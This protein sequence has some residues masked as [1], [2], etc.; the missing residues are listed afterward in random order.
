M[1]STSDPAV[2]K[3]FLLSHPAHLISL[4]FGS[5]LSRFAPG[6]AGTILG[7]PLFLLLS[8]LS[9]SLQISLLALLFIAGCYLCDFTGKALG[10]SDHGS[11]VWDEIV[12]YA[13]VL[14]SVPFHW[15]WWIGAFAAFRFFDIIKP[16]PIS[17]L[18]RRLKNGF[19]VM[20]DD[21]LAAIYAIITLH[22]FK[23]ML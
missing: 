18:D 19:G 20:L 11:I 6:T 7:L 15:M 8:P 3:G 4:G 2:P 16:W 10:V 5:G 9:F 22:L 1:A 21:L 23:I 17:W 14:T 12:A 13:L